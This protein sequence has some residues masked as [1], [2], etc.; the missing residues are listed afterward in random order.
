[1]YDKV[2][3]SV[4]ARYPATALVASP[5]TVKLVGRGVVEPGAESPRVIVLQA[6]PVR[7]A[8]RD[9]TGRPMQDRW[10]LPSTDPRRTFPSHVVEAYGPGV[11][12]KQG[13]QIDVYV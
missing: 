6:R 5:R 4:E 12:K 2:F 10:A 3:L 11:S 1:M 9:R 7:V 8:G 13:T